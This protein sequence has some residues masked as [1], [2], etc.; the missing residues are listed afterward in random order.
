MT[1]EEL[2]ARFAGVGGEATVSGGG[3]FARATVRVEPARWVE[4]VRFARDELGC[5]F[6]DWLSAV[7]ELDQGFAV[8]AHLWSTR[9]RHGVLL[10]TV[11][12]VDAP[13]VASVVALYPG[14]AWHERET[15]E[16]F[17]IDFPGHPG[18]LRP[19]LLPPE[20]VGYPLRKQ[21]I[22]ASRVAKPWP[23]AKE[24]GESH[25]A[26]AA[27]RAP[28]RPPGVPAPGE[29]GPPSPEA[30]TPPR[31]ARRTPGAESGTDSG[32]EG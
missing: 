11:V 25:D 22:L 2:G 7:D 1:P 12:P 9:Q 20:F 17:G 5:D 23:G 27:R 15:H 24:P 30:P 6:F 26:G 16:M 10:Q 8:V 28:M 21:F 32:G 13:A 31:P 4:A 3:A 18:Q 19:L 29:W 14:A